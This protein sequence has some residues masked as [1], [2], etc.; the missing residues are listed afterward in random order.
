M[1][2]HAITFIIS[3]CILVACGNNKTAGLPPAPT[4]VDQVAKT[5]EGKKYKGSQL[6]L[7]STNIA[8]KNNPYE[9]F[10]EINDTTLFFK[11]F[12]SQQL[13][14]GIHFIND[15]SVEVTE[16]AGTNRGTWKIETEP[17]R[18][19]TPGIFSRITFEKEVERTPGQINKST[20]TYSYKVLGI[21]NKQLF[22][23]TPNVFKG[24]KLAILLKAE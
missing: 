1:R 7:V 20:W 23:T 13:Q 15:T 21:D 9:W 3:A 8:D 11:K 4:G 22:L 16:E 2:T 14:L 24:K 18:D 10:D 6:A 17:R 19:E 12:E 5:V